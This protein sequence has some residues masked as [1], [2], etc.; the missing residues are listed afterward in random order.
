M[1]K[2][3]TFLTLL[4][5]PCA[6]LGLSVNTDEP[7]VIK[8]DKVEYD[9]NSETIK[10]TGKTEITNQSGQ[11][12]TLG[13]SK[14][15]KDGQNLS[16]NE[17]Q[18]WLGEHV[19]VE[20]E[21]ITRNKNITIAKDALF[22]ACKNCD[23]FGETWE[24]SA[25]EI[26]H[27]MDERML[28]FYNPIFWLYDIPIFWSPYFSLPDPGVKHKTGLLSPSMESTNKMG[29]QINLPLY[30]YISD[31][32]DLT[33][34]FSYLTHENPLFQLEHRLNAPH[35][36]F[37]TRGSFTHNREGKNRWHIFNN[38]IIELGE[39]ARASI[40]LE[41][42]SDKTYLQKYGF[43][44]EQP[45][46]DSGAKLEVFGQS[47]YVSADVHVFQEL[48]QY[49]N[50]YS[51]PNGNI[52]PNIRGVYQTT[53]LFA[54]TYTLFTGDILG[55]SGENEHSER[56]IG[57][58]RIISP[59]TIWAGNRITASLATRYD[60]YNFNNTTMI[61][62]ENYSGIK[63]RFL[64][65]GYLEWGLPLF[66]PST[67]WTQVLEPRAR[68][69]VMRHISDNQFARDNDSVGALLSDTTLFS[70]NRFSGLDLWENGTFADYGVRWS[71]FA[72]DGKIIE[73]FVG[74]TY[75]F[76]N[77]QNTDPNSGFHNGLSDYVG[78]VGYNNMDW[79]NIY[80]RFRFNRDDF[81]LRHSET[82]MVIGTPHNFLNIGHIWSRQFI[83]A[84]TQNE[85]IHEVTGGV[86]LAITDR[87]SLRLNAIYNMT[88]EQ[89]QQHNGALY[90]EHP[91]YYLSFGYKRDNA[92]KQDYVGTTTFQFSFG[93]SIDGKHY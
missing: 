93:I 16:G 10:T 2:S 67:E 12:M 8:A 3:Y 60:L 46:L 1:K 41:R 47:S 31:T 27:D 45:Y 7:T 4:F 63:G 53:P 17:I 86:G 84:G 40:F 39:N 54:E 79:L 71:A 36:E 44:N 9:L 14:F 72:P 76:T 69:T 52:L 58:A 26:E 82:N 22:T 73:A 13:D 65:S 81:N 24:I 66:R 19:Y 56:M 30:I 78:R 29:T 64:P 18:I 25:T 61:D 90:Y 43:Y 68:F 20:S 80:T 51:V 21:N 62:G 59:W 49:S 11:K 57:E 35:S 34:T 91:C 50:R 48:R 55:I 33:T 28:D 23:D 87:W 83:E 6:A 42:A 77:R 32:H 37:R 15:T 89:F 74:Q 70:N 85:Y 92:I 5:A 88:F 75:D 38:D